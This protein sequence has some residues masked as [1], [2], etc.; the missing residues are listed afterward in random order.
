MGPGGNKIEGVFLKELLAYRELGSGQSLYLCT[1]GITNLLAFRF[2][3]SRDSIIKQHRRPGC[4]VCSTSWTTPASLK[5]VFQT[6]S[7]VHIEALGLARL[8]E[9]TQLTDWA[10]VNVSQL[11]D[12]HV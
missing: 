7:A 5:P 4:D 6:L 11:S 9:Y 1:L 8:D 12:D 3:I 2:L 10:G